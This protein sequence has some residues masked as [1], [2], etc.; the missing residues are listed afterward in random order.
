MKTLFVLI[1]V[2]INFCAL[3]QTKTKVIDSGSAY[4][5]Y[6][7]DKKSLKMFV[8]DKKNRSPD[9]YSIVSDSLTLFLNKRQDFNFYLGWL[10]PL[11]YKV[12][13]IES[14][15]VDESYRQMES[16][17]SSLMTIFN[18]DVTS[19]SKSV[20]QDDKGIVP[21]N[22]K[23]SNG[24]QT[25]NVDLSKIIEIDFP[26]KVMLS[27]DF[28]DF[29]FFL[30]LIDAEDLGNG[31][32]K[33]I[34]DM[35]KDIEEF[36]KSNFSDFKDWYFTSFSTLVSLESAESAKLSVNSIN[37]ALEGKE[38]NLSKKPDLISGFKNKVSL[39]SLENKMFEY[40]MKSKLNNAIVDAE[41]RIKAESEL[42]DKLKPLVSI[43]EDSLKDPSNDSGFDSSEFFESK[44]LS[45]E[46]GKQISAKIIVK[47]YSFDQKSLSFSP[48]EE[49][50]SKKFVLRKYNFIYPTFSTGVFY[51]DTE[52]VTYGLSN[53]D[54]SNEFLISQDT[55]Q[56]NTALVAA[57][58]NFNFDL[59]SDFFHPF[60]QVGIDPTKIRPF[61]LLGGGIFVPTSKFAIS[62]GAV[63]TWEQ[64]L[65]NL[66]VGDSVNS[67][68]DL[69]NDIKYGVF[70]VGVKGWY[71]GIQYQF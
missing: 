9:G 22:D 27:P 8:I 60:L 47:E 62:G 17:V 34:N 50:F 29:Y 33:V 16:F 21:V 66:K 28:Q 32:R 42:K 56:K 54:N 23:S 37:L 57:F 49:E 68:T 6:S 46:T 51:S 55:L 10:N 14:V 25:S 43:I 5:N 20:N 67:T 53:S 38:E 12:S 59:N 58:A 63:F 2:I 36:D 69:Q 15:S 26:S 65:E 11:K 31:D 7:V 18:L 70:D 39:V 71:L 30:S 64:S 4:L 61:L 19:G 1:L 52:I 48:L 24:K 13:W 41:T 3:G 35:K 45:F 40:Q 44:S